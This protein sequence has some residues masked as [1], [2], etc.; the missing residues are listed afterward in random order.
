MSEP[1]ESQPPLS[2]YLQP[3]LPAARLERNRLA[4]QR[5]LDKPARAARAWLWAGAACA[6]AAVVLVWGPLRDVTGA[7][8]TTMV[9]DWQPVAGAVLESERDGLAAA[10]RDGT[11][12]ELEPRTE[13]AAASPSAATPGA[14]ARDLAA[15]HVELELR[16]GRASFDVT[17]APERQFRVRAGS[18]S[19]VVLGTRF[20]VGRTDGT[21]NVAVERGKVAVDDGH[22]VTYLT[23]GERWQGADRETPALSASF[24]P[25]AA[26]SV[27]DLPAEAATLAESSPAAQMEADRVDEANVSAASGGRAAPSTVKPNGSSTATVG[28]EPPNRAKELF[29]A[30]REARRVGDSR[31]AAQLL[32]ELVTHHATDPRA[33]LAAFELGRIRADVLG[34]LSGAITALEQALRLSPQGSFRQ[35]ALARLALAY[36]R[37]GRSAACKA[38]RERY[39]AAYGEGVHAQRVVKLCP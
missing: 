39:L 15:P 5:R 17:H 1:D 19:V 32:Q 35:D 11:R 4:V 6:A 28:L 36:D 33:G 18:V 9:R 27:P 24:A 13:L 26:S 31:R 10:L 2:A 14:G 38:T 7:G 25:A 21:V 20:S 30:S 12:L 29:D 8:E 37:A 3:P 16:R 22:A 34:D 23:P